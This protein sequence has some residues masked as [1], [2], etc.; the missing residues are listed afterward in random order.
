MLS[1]QYLIRDKATFTEKKNIT[2]ND[3][4]VVNLAFALKK[5]MGLVEI[6]SSPQ[7]EVEIN[8]KS[9]GKTPIEVT[10]MAVEQKIT[11]HKR[12]FRS[13]TKRITPT[14]AKTKYINVTLISEKLA[15][16]K[17]TRQ[18]YTH[19]AGGRLKLFRPNDTFVMGA[20]RSEKGQRA[21][22]FL[23]KVRLTKAFYAGISEVTNAEFR[24]FN[25]SKAGTANYPVTS[26]LWIDAA[27]FCNWLS[28]LEGLD[29]VYKINKHQL[30]GVNNNSNGYRLLT[31]AEWEWLARK[32]AKSVQTRFV[33]GD[34]YVIPKKSVNIADELA[35]GSVKVFVSQYNDGYAGIAPVK[36]FSQEKSGLYDQGGNV[37][38][39][40]HDNYS[41]VLPKSGKVF[42]N[43]FDLSK[44]NSHVVKGANWRSG[45]V[46]ELRSSFREGLVNARD[47]L[48][49]RIGRY[50]DGGN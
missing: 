50:V 31:E 4:Q 21:N 41:I 18:I 45:S 16:L 1:I 28:Q 8:G 30:I 13:I 48:G 26:V 17:E 23:K 33:W 2:L 42:K 36:S 24:H 38:E 27:K 35:K 7:V 49:F 9:I 19:K 10:L 15:Q 3:D 29:P 6:N 32:S 22:E 47:D 20:H 12:G 46:T 11:L 14:A 39:W 34:G 43:P 5:E 37:S 25:K 40:T 44:G